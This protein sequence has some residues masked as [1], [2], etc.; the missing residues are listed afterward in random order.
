M[1]RDGDQ[2]PVEEFEERDLRFG[3]EVAFFFTVSSSRVSSVQKLI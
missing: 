2:I 1:R 3:D